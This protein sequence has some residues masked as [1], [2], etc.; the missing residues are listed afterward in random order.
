MQHELPCIPH[1]RHRQP[2]KKIAWFVV[3]SNVSPARTTS[4]L[5]TTT[6]T[7][8]TTEDGRP[9]TLRSRQ[10][11][12]P[13]PPSP[14]LARHALP[15]RLPTLPRPPATNR[16]RNISL[17]R[18]RLR[19]PHP[20]RDNP[21]FNR[22]LTNRGFYIYRRKRRPRAFGLAL[23]QRNG[24]HNNHL[25]RSHRFL[26]LHP[27]PAA[28]LERR[29]HGRNN[30]QRGVGVFRTVGDDVWGREGAVE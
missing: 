28:V 6:H 7:T 16:S 23:R 17:P 13:H 19:A 30:F 11:R 14:P 2:F 25:P 22:D 4:H 9:D 10:R 1:R 8:L 27:T 12:L 21:A 3:S 29:L 18:S 24:S 26:P 20:R 5:Y 15:N